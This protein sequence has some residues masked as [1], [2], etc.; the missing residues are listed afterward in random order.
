M[1][2]RLVLVLKEDRRCF[3]HLAGWDAFFVYWVLFVIAQ[4]WVLILQDNYIVINEVWLC[5][6]NQRSRHILPT[7]RMLHIGPR[8]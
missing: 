7:M 4:R 5:G 8:F 6:T 1:S 2:F 3:M